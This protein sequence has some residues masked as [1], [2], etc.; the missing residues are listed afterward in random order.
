MIQLLKEMWKGCVWVLAENAR[1]WWRIYYLYH[2]I[3]CFFMKTTVGTVFIDYFQLQRKYQRQSYVTNGWFRLISEIFL[4]IYSCISHISELTG[5]FFS[6]NPTTTEDII[7][8]LFH[9][10]IKRERNGK[11][12]KFNWVA[13][14]SCNWHGIFKVNEPPSRPTHNYNCYHCLNWTIPLP[15]VKFIPYVSTSLV[16]SISVSKRHQVNLLKIWVLLGTL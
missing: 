3:N 16:N 6:W 15:T 11:K 12:R 9:L 10:G 14:W 5:V 7:S 8:P 1:L 2:G 13:M 4:L